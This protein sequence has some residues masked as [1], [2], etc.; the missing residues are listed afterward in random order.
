MSENTETD[1]I[2]LK[3]P[4]CSKEHVEKTPKFLSDETR[5]HD[6]TWNELKEAAMA[7]DFEKSETFSAYTIEEQRLVKSLIVAQK[8]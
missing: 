4:F 1:Q 8:I 5:V 3:C 2:T 7:E 6:T